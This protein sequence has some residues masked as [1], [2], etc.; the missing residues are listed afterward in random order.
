MIQN[1]G[2]HALAN[3]NDHSWLR[4]KLFFTLTDPS[5][6]LTAS[7]Q[8]ERVVRQH[9]TSDRRDGETACAALR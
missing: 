8:K 1:T 4:H 7:Q 5:Q 9:W 2:H 3:I 6:G